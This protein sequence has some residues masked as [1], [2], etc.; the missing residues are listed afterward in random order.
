MISK[1]QLKHIDAD[2]LLYHIELL[3]NVTQV[4]QIILKAYVDGLNKI[5][6]IFKHKFSDVI[7]EKLDEGKYSYKDERISEL[8]DGLDFYEVTIK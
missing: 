7:L 8:D 2:A 4:E 6:V 5:T 3:E 1:E